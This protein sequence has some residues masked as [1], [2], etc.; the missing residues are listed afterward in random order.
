MNL[1]D[2]LREHVNDDR[3]IEAVLLNASGSNGYSGLPNGWVQI[4]SGA[5]NST[6]Y[7]SLKFRNGRIAQLKIGQPLSSLTAQD[8]LV[9]RARF[10]IA[11]MHGYKVVERHL[12]ASRKL[13][14]S[15]SYKDKIQIDPLPAEVPIGDGLNFFGRGQWNSIGELAD[16]PPYPFSLRIRIPGS[17]NDTIETNRTLDG[18]DTVQRL[19]TLLVS[20][21]IHT[22]ATSGERIWTLVK[23]EAK[24]ENHLLHPGFAGG[25]NYKLPEFD[26]PF[27]TH[28]LMY[29]REDYYNHLWQLDAHISIPPTLDADL[30]TFESLGVDD[31]SAFKRAIYWYDLGL[32]NRKES[33]I[34]TPA[35][36]TAIECLLPKTKRER[37]STCN[38]EV[39]PGPTRLF[40][41]FLERYGT[42]LESLHKNRTELYN[43]RSAL[44]H[45]GFAASVDTGWQSAAR[46]TDEH[47]MLLELVT[48]RSLINWLRD[49]DRKN[50]NAIN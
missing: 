12:L 15:Y 26:L 38:S 22:F 32:R 31:K 5:A 11:H 21:N 33:A 30:E 47:G 20:G 45:G 6:P 29:E 37:C 49:P 40:K 28:A 10:E 50:W 39:G 9:D 35:L 3:D 1:L 24:L 19:L 43:I 13:T 44:V 4:Y 18:L 34:S 27:G 23:R 46:H 14:G 16:G 42:V 41:L 25:E 2:R 36:S 8:A 17:P 7:V 48:R